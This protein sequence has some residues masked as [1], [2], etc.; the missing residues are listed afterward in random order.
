MQAGGGRAGTGV[1]Q[2]EMKIFICPQSR[3]YANTE[4]YD[5]KSHKSGENVIHG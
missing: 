2:G 1:G 4:A 5:H 3:K